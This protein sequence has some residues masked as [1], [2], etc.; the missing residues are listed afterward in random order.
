MNVEEYDVKSLVSAAIKKAAL[1]LEEFVINETFTAKNPAGAIF[2]AKAALGYRETAPEQ[3]NSQQKLPS[4][5]N[6]IVM[7]QPEKPK[8]IQAIE[9]TPIEITDK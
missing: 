1:R 5:I 8:E 7:P 4:S 6:I 9:V 3:D 2:Y